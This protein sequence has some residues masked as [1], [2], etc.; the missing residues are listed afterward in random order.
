M[1]W[2][3]EV[4]AGSLAFTSRYRNDLAAAPTVAL[5]FW[6]Y[7]SSN[8]Q[9][10]ARLSRSTGAQR[11]N[12]RNWKPKNQDHFAKCKCDS[13][14]TN[15]CRLIFCGKVDESEQALFAG[16]GMHAGQETLQPFEVAAAFRCD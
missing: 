15:L 7:Q 3:C 11:Q 16:Q 12:A 10:W 4:S 13:L 14:L 9:T 8:Q 6:G 2:S 1:A 5:Q